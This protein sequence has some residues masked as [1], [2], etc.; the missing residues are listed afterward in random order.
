MSIAWFG[1]TTARR[2]TVPHSPIPRSRQRFQRIASLTI[3]FMAA[4][5]IGIAVTF[6]L[7]NLPLGG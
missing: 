5:L 3:E 7:L 4:A 6:V 2:M 1:H